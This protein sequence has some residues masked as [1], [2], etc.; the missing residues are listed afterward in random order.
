MEFR[1]LGPLDVRDGD[2]TVDVSGTKHRVLL[3]TLLLH[4]GEVVSTERLIEALWEDGPP[5]T[6]QKTLHVYISQLRK[7][8]GHD[9][10]RTQPPG[11]L[12]RVEEDELDLARFERL[13]GR[14]RHAEALA[15]W[16]GPPLAEFASE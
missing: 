15:L 10:I 12:L 5:P 2:R 14:G 7:A 8:L 6:A 3:A 13:V 9:R 16:R 4:A 11:Y 1:I